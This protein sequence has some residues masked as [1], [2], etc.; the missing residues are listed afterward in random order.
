MWFITFVYKNLARRPL[1]SFLTVVAIAIAIGSFVSLVGIAGG[2]ESSFLQIYEGSGMDILVI[3]KGAQ[4]GLTSTLDER[5]AAKIRE[6]PGVKNVIGGLT[7]M[8]NF[9]DEDQFKALFNGWEPETVAFD[10]IRILDGRNLTKTDAKCVLL[11]KQLAS[12]I[13]KKVGDSI[14][15]AEME[16]FKVV[17]IY[18]T[19]NLFENGAL[20]IPLTELQRM[21]GQKGLVTGFTV[22]MEPNKK[23]PA[24]IAETC[25]RIKKISSSMDPQDYRSFVSSRPELQIAKTMAWVTS[26]IALLIGTFGM[27]NTMVMSIHERTKEIGTLRAVGWRRGRVIRMILLEALLLSVVGALVGTVGSLSLLWILAHLPPTNLFIDGRMDHLIII[28]GFVIALLVGF[29]GGLFPA[30]RGARLLPVEAL[31]HE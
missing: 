8:M 3:R 4:Q 14:Q 10:H 20:V 31:R 19:N 13:D 15:L 29:F 16:I 6:Q 26:M 27:M 2:F 1:R 28:E 7:G 11:G 21:I 24:S 22:M 30:W 5:L 18:D 23:D 25:E 17:G 9:G 12:N